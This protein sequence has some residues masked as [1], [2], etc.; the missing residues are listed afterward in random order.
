M[1]FDDVITYYGTQSKACDALDLSRASFS[2]WRK[3][4]YIP[5]IS[6][7]RFEQATKGKLKADKDNIHKGGRRKDN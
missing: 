2:K 1:T 6:Q 5:L 3:Q 7:L 4:G